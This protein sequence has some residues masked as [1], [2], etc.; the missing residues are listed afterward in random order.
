MSTPQRAQ[1]SSLLARVRARLRRERAAADDHGDG[2]LN[3]VPYL[4]ITVN[5]VIFLLATAASALPISHVPVTVPSTTPAITDPGGVVGEALSLTVAVSHSGFI[6]AEAGRVLSGRDGKLPTLPCTAMAAI[7]CA[8]Y[9]DAGLTEL[10]RS[11][12]RRHPRVRRVELLADERIPYQVVVRAMDA[13]R[14]TPT[15]LCTGSD[16]CLFDRVVLGTG[17]Q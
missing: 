7:G 2:E 9:D 12:K 4:D 11:I 16:G 15:T 14:G 1:A 6:V 8:T 13:V 5:V 17:V 10:A 3:L